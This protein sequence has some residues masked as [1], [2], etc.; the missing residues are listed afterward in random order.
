MTKCDCLRKHLNGGECDC[1]DNLDNLDVDNWEENYEDGD[2]EVEED[3]DK[4]R[5][6]NRHDDWFNH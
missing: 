3:E 4:T 5:I 6:T 1:L 2:V